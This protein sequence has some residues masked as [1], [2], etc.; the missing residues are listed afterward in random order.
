MSVDFSQEGPLP[1]VVICGP[2]ASGKTALALNLAE[3]FP[4]EIISADSRQV[5][6]G[7]DIGTAKATGQERAAVPHHLV[8]V[9]DPDEE[10]T[11]GRFVTLSRAALR[12]IT[13][14]GHRPLLVGG[15]GLY[16]K[17]FTEGLLEAPAADES[18]RTRLTDLEDQQGM[19]TL[20]ARLQQVDP[21]MAERLSPRDQVRLVR[22]LEVF[23][24]TGRRLSELQARHGFSDNPFRLLK[25]G[26][27]AD[28]DALYRRI[29]ERVHRMV[30]MGLVD[31]VE[32]LLAKG[33]SPLLKSMQTI[34]YREIIHFLQGEISLDEAIAR[35]QQQSRRY[36]KRQ[37]TWFRRDST[38]IWVDSS[39]ES[40]K[41]H[42]LMEC[43][44][45]AS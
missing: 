17:T 27:T 31:E 26:V 10:F 35:I 33:Y 1:L 43:F 2:T 16:I 20:H 4:V 45:V 7:M 15:T 5:Y 9:V 41:I 25:I 19:G 40:D 38:I 12:S 24:L 3:K 14:R 8:D 6:R 42:E 30:E 29:D 13:L 32:S 44:Y 22:A 39:K 23:E 21:V 37:M 11:A 34:G 36:A 18:L 28:R